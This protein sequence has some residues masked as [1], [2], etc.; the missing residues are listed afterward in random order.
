MI[1]THDMYKNWVLVAN[2]NDERC[3]VYTG[4]WLTDEIKIIRE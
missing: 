3:K 2:N 1:I 4:Q